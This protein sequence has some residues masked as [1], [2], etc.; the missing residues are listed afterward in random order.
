M[1]NDSGLEAQ[2]RSLG[3]Q[4]AARASFASQKSMNAEAYFRSTSQLILK[5]IARVVGSKA[6][7]LSLRFG[8]TRDEPLITQVKRDGLA[9]KL[10]DIGNLDGQPELYGLTQEEFVAGNAKE[11]RQKQQGA[12]IASLESDDF[13]PLERYVLAGNTL[14][15]YMNYEALQGVRDANGERVISDTTLIVHLHSYYSARKRRDLLIC[16][17]LYDYGVDLRL[18]VKGYLLDETSGALRSTAIGIIT[19]D[20]FDTVPKEPDLPEHLIRKILS[21]ELSQFRDKVIEMY[22]SVRSRSELREVLASKG[23][24]FPL[25]SE[26]QQEIFSYLQQPSPVSAEQISIAQEMV[27]NLSPAFEFALSLS[28]EKEARDEAVRQ[29]SLAAIGSL[30]GEV[31]HN[32]K[33][34]L[35]ALQ[36][37]VP[38]LRDEAI[39]IPA[40][41]ARLFRKTLASESNLDELLALSIECAETKKTE[42]L[43]SRDRLRQ[44]RILN[45][46]YR[47]VFDDDVI[48]KVAFLGLS[49]DKIEWIKAV[50]GQSALPEVLDLAYSVAQ[51]W[52]SASGVTQSAN[53]TNEYFA[54]LNN[55]TKAGSDDF[56]PQSLRTS[57][58]NSLLLMARPLRNVTIHKSFSDKGEYEGNQAEISMALMNLLRNSKEAMDGSGDLYINTWCDEGNLYASVEDSGPGVSPAVLSGLF[59]GRVSTKGQGRGY[60]LQSARDSLSKYGGSLTYEPAN[61]G[62]RFVIRLPKRN[63]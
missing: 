8:S 54:I 14:N 34:P 5:E 27:E 35:S 15:Y 51:T 37:N 2:L 26:E 31:A 52:Y 29:S 56:A 49:S 20:T 39:S 6:A 22:Q 38:Y 47:G 55:I 43:S 45:Q 24:V 18:P 57:I 19:I 63:I 10:Y 41:T 33:N 53:Q 25:S 21:D 36:G 4:I 44:K 13:F 60:G 1:H 12:V 62:A 59:S 28:R 11:M 46:M 9:I 32:L 7:R 42:G 30:A 58:E 23:I 3:R 16:R 61:R 50:F 17:G 40:K 48:D